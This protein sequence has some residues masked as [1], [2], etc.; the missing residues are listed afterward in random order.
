MD[1]LIIE[2]EKI[3]EPRWRA[4]C[5]AVGG[6][7]GER[8]ASAMKELCSIYTPDVIDWFAS[9]YDVKSAGWYYSGS[10]RDNESVEYNGKTYLLRPDLESTWQA[11]GFFKNSG[12][13][14]DFDNELSRALPEWIGNDLSEWAI[15]CQD[16]DGYF[17]HEQWGKSIGLSR[18]GR[19]LWW[20]SNIIKSFGKEKKYISVSDGEK[21]RE[22]EEIVLPEHLKSKENFAKYLESKN[23]GENSYVTGNDLAC[24]SDLIRHAGLAE[25]CIEFLD[26]HQNENGLWHNEE[27]YYAINGVMKITCVYNNMHRMIPHAE[28]IVESCIRVLLSDEP[29]KGAVDVYNPWFAMGNLISSIRELGD[30]GAEDAKRIIKFI[31]SL[32]PD[33][34]RAT[35]RKI[36]VFK[37][38]SG[39]F[40]Y[41][42]KTSAPRSQ[43]MPVAIEGSAE[44][45]I[46]GHILSSTGLLHHI[47]RGLDLVD[48]KVPLFTHCDF[49]RYI[50]I[51][52][53]K[54]KEFGVI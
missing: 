39:S 36:V 33:A 3:R 9:L 6:D 52:E 42:V 13:I 38:E 27:N 40:S 31:R 5:D 48:Y 45:D 8:I 25:Q 29:V 24:Q 2:R 35:A 7:V 11:L 43:G 16:P 51:L 41:G 17:Y 46:N 26:A 19:D 12:M 54:R 21:A 50:E 34:I 1:S 28:E 47:Y 32:A 18:R 37:K 15:S 53:R 44:G 10:A 4:L 22:S 23:I 20:A 30:N 49:D 14:E